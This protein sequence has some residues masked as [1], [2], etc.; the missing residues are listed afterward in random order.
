MSI[1]I[2]T[3]NGFEPRAVCARCRRPQRVCY[4]RHIT[5]I[6]TA[7]RI[8]LLQ[9]P[10]ERDVAIGT[11]RMASLCLPS[12][13]LHVG[14]DWDGSPDLAR[15]LS[16]PARPPA[17]L[18][19]G[20]GAID[21]AQSPPP[22]PITLVVVDGTWSQTKTLV[23]HNSR[24]AALPRYA[25][26]PP[27]PSEYRI[28]R[29]PRETYVSTIEALVHVLG[30]LEGSPERFAALLLP[31]RA[32]VDVQIE[33]ER[34]IHGARLRHGRTNEG[35]PRYPNLPPILRERAGDLVCVLGEANAWPFRPPM[36]SSAYP[37][38]LAQ[39]IA[40]RASTGEVLERVIA[41][42]H[43]LGPNTTVHTRLS[44]ERLATGC[45]MAELFEAWNAFVRPTDVL[46][47]WG[48]H[49]KSLF[50]NAGGALPRE[51]LDMRHTTRTFA[52]GRLGHLEELAA[53]F[54][55]GAVPA[56][57]GAGR[58]GA[59]LGQLVAVTRH[60]VEVVSGPPEKRGG[61]S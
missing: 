22:G 31:F 19:P 11:A 30:V 42:S 32:M 60:L 27:A 50:A 5:P 55:G 17:L 56:S 47:F 21:I 38:E 7:T 58:A 8:V 29:E 34:R 18:Y 45:S 54:S 41:P 48:P 26:V 20:E 36:A 28:R 44:A 2:N 16:D 14:V 49:A 37:D 15:A 35:A 59:R 1:V 23:R 52:K 25:F 10:R 40:C 46:C 51:L 13:E 6:E 39:W 43:P 4:C 61:A 33:H 24:L 57:L 53:R 9:H 12:S 3:P